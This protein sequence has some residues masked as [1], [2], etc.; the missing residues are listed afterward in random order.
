MHI[1]IGEN[2]QVIGEM[3]ATLFAA[4]I[5]R[6]P[7]SVLGLSTGSSPLPT[8]AALVRRYLAGELDVSRITSFNL[9]EYV[10]LAP[11][12]PESYHHFMWSHLFTPMGMRPEQVHLPHGDAPDPQAECARYDA[13]I[14]AAGGIDLQLLGIGLNGHIGFNEPEPVFSRRAHVIDLTPSTLEAN[15]CHFATE[16]E[17]PRQAITVSI[18]GIFQARSI[19]LI[20][21][22]EAKADIVRA[23]VEGEIV[24]AVP[25]SI[26][27]LHSDV[28]VLLDRAAASRL[29][30]ACA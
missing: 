13:A 5:L 9:D 2:P 11:D 18:R 17:M 15:R 22:G 24:P 21:C 20:A 7:D 16:A 23:M 14:A 25:A 30:C 28:H 4:Q 8:Y 12:H 10:G 6:K 19:V 3:T 29:T 1:H 27:Q 26:L